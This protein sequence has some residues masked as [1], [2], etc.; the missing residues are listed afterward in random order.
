M[1]VIDFKP[2]MEQPSAATWRL[3]TSRWAKSNSRELMHTL[4]CF[5]ES[6]SS[7][8]ERGGKPVAGCSPFGSQRAV[9]APRSNAAGIGRRASVL[10]VIRAT[11][12]SEYGLLATLGTA[13]GVSAGSS[14]QPNPALKRTSHGRPWAAA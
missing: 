5:S 14:R 11:R 6:I 4:S 13:F 1:P 3:S 9:A 12:Q 10:S 7:H 8:A 2:G